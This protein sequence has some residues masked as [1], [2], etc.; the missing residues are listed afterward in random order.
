MLNEA[1]EAVLRSPTARHHASH[2][3][4][5]PAGS[6]APVTAGYL[7]PEFGPV[8]RC[9]RRV[10]H[11]QYRK[12]EALQVKLPAE[13]VKP[14]VESCGAGL[15][16]PAVPATM[17]IARPPEHSIGCRHTDS[18]RGDLRKKPGQDRGQPTV[19]WTGMAGAV[20]YLNARP[21]D[22]QLLRAAAG[23]SAARPGQPDRPQCSSRHCRPAPQRAGR[24]IAGWLSPRRW[25]QATAS[26]TSSNNPPGDAFLTVAFPRH[27]RGARIMTVHL[28]G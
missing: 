27:D 1:R 13:P 15:N 7:Q 9:N 22:A 8:L 28:D 26:S 5:R 18:R 11:G 24:R 19:V 17:Q 16:K 3:Q 10:P 6:P 21:Q 20:P 4:K 12:L 25:R 23:A 14:A 2:P